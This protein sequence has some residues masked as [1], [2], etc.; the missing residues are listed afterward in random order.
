MIF[1]KT[2]ADLLTI[3]LLLEIENGLPVLFNNQNF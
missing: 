1:K 2:F 3:R